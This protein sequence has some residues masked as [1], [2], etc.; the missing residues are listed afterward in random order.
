MNEN[1][2]YTIRLFFIFL[3]SVFIILVYTVSA[4]SSKDL[5]LLSLGFVMTFGMS[6]GS[7]DWMLASHWR[8]RQNYQQSILFLFG[9]IGVAGVTIIIWYLLPTL[10]FCIFLLMSALHF[11]NDWQ[12]ELDWQAR[13]ILGVAVIS[14]P[15]IFFH[16]EVLSLFKLLVADTSAKIITQVLQMVAYVS[17]ALTLILAARKITYSYLLTLE[18][19]TLLITGLLL[20]PII[21]FG[22]YFC[23]LHASKH[24][25]HM[26]R[27]GMYQSVSEVLGSVIWLTV[28]C[29]FV[30][31]WVITQSSTWSFS[32]A[33]IRTVFIG[34]AA[35][36]VPH[37]LL[38]EVY[39]WV[40][41]KKIN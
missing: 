17:G 16:A 34:L 37:W 13:T 7:L 20:P 19:I 32:N 28:L 35:L 8:I 5:E 30:A 9:Y 27:I 10:A 25:L 41:R 2:F 15:A 26:K 3:T 22:I 23:V 12:G 18:I 24:W 6:H 14:I 36:T 21:Y 4:I 33:L 38:L 11:A 39:P 31:I 29:I 1:H 40:I